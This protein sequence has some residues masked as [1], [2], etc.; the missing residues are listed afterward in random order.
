MTDTITG[1]TPELFASYWAAPDPA[2]LPGFV[3]DD[4]VGHW[5][6][7]RTVRGTQAYVEALEDLLRL[8]PDIRLEVPAGATN[9]EYGFVRWIMHAT[10]KYGPFQLNGADCITTRNG[11][12]CEN[13]IN[14]DTAEFHRL[15]GHTLEI[16]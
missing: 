4:V 1:W 11:L 13:Y 16:R 9:G 7:N 15:S 3:T 5:P 6:G 2:P 14:F 10:G 8:L 12:V